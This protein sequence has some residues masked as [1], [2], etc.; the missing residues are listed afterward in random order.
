MKRMIVFCGPILAS[1]HFGKLPDLAIIRLEAK[2]F[3][4]IGLTVWG[5]RCRA[6]GF[7]S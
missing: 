5:L 6:W 4:L 7:V 2:G 1:P 3:W